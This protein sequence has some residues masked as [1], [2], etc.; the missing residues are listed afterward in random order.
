MNKNTFYIVVGAAVILVLV[1]WK[2][3][4]DE[5]ETETD[6]NSDDSGIPVPP[7]KYIKKVNTTQPLENAVIDFIKL[8]EGGLSKDPNDSASKNPVPDGSGNHT[9]KGITWKTFN[10]L[11]NRLGYNGNDI[12]L[13]YEMP[14][15]IWTKIYKEIYLSPFTA[16]TLSPLANYYLSLWAWGSGVNG[17]K[18][19]IDRTGGSS[20][21]YNEIIRTQGEKALLIKL[22]KERMDFFRRLAA[23]KIEN[24]K[25]L[26]G[27]LYAQQNFYHN[28]KNYIK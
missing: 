6:M 15:S 5:N 19:L 26:N 22:V 14:L 28:F 24:Q 7:A 12:K 9:N 11:G 20:A 2:R 4:K 13:F 18:A 1:L 27:W 17:A 8:K 3:K 10:T 21:A 25:F 23:A 16:Y